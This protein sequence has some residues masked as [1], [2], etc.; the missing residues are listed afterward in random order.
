MCCVQDARDSSPGQIAAD[1]RDGRAVEQAASHEDPAV[2]ASIAQAA[3]EALPCG[4]VSEGIRLM[5]LCRKCIEVRLVIS[6]GTSA[7]T[8]VLSG[9]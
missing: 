6:Q 8:S 1:G 9:L 5:A 2:I 7:S 4:G 3:L